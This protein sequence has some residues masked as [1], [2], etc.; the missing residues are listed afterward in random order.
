MEK[1]I[2]DVEATATKRP[3][4]GAPTG[5]AAKAEPVTRYCHGHLALMPTPATADGL[6]EQFGS[7][8][9][10][11]ICD[12]L[13]E[14][15]RKHAAANEDL[16]DW[17][18]IWRWLKG[19]SH[20]ACGGRCLDNKTATTAVTEADINEQ[21]ASILANVLGNAVL[22][23][24]YGI[25]GA[26]AAIVRDLWGRMRDSLL[27][28]RD[29][30][31]ALGQLALGAVIGACIGLFVT[32]SNASP[33]EATGL[34]GSVTLSASALSFVA[35]FSVEG[36]FVALESFIKRVFNIDEPGSRR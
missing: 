35:G 21:W 23:V 5:A 10:R 22:P 14:N 36:M 31:L 4:T 9:Q 24:F 34:T 12:Q 1:K 29:V 11:Q 17:L 16:A 2:A 8:T 15:R 30:T 7:V 20:V 33:Q 6:G 19:I 32:P 3:D 27:S 26:G 13:V 25:L 18:A 28:P